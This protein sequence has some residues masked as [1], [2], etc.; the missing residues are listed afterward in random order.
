MAWSVLLQGQD[1][2]WLETKYVTA[3]G[4]CGLYC[5]IKSLKVGDE[6]GALDGSVPSELL[7][8]AVL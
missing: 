8:T 2:K 4:N 3:D 6:H 7:V 5:V 1:P